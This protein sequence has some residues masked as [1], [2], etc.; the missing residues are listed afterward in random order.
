[1]KEMGVKMIKT[2]KINIGTA[3]IWKGKIRR[4]R[5]RE[6]RRKIRKTGKRKRGA[7]NLEATVKTLIKAWPVSQMIKI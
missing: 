3:R 7:R 1:M 6:I 5:R 2:R 4:K